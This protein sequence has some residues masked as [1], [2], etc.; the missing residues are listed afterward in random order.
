VRD[1]EAAHLIDAGDDLEETMDRIEAS[2]TPETGI[3]RRRRGFLALE[4]VRFHGPDDAT[5]IA[6]DMRI[7]DR[8]DEPASGVIEILG[9]G[10][11]QC[12]EDCSIL[13]NNGSRGR[14]RPLRRGAV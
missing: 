6:D 5:R 9:V 3:D 4:A 11:R 1:V 12:V 10:K 13:L 14:F 7:L 2:L 8:A